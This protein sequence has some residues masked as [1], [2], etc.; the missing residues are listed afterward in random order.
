M[1]NKC[2]R[3]GTI[4]GDDDPELMN[5]CSCGGRLFLFL[6]KGEELKEESNDVEELMWLEKE[7]EHVLEKSEAP[8]SLDVETV[9]ILSKGKF[10]VDVASL[11]S[12]KPLIV[13]GEDGVYYIDLTS[14][15]KKKVKELIPK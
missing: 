6:R 1:P 4:Y 9:R 3:C 14:M 11:M 7:L 5:G 10:E 13:K 2:T 8:I 12:G 15:M